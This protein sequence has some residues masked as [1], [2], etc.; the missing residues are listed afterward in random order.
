MG[1]TIVF[2]VSLGTADPA[3]KAVSYDL[4]KKDLEE[5]SGLP[6]WEI[7]TDRAAADATEAMTFEEALQKAEQEGYENIRIV[8][9]FLTKGD[10]FYE[11]KHTVESYQD[12]FDIKI[13]DA[14]LADRDSTAFAAGILTQCLH[15][16]PDREYVLAAY[17]NP[18]F[19]GMAYEILQTAFDRNGYD[20][21][22]VAQK[23]SNPG[24]PECVEFLR[25]RREGRTDLKPVIL[26]PLIV[27]GG[28]AQ[29]DKLIGETDSFASALR[30]AG[31]EVEAQNKGLG[32][33]KQFRRIYTIRLSS[34]NRD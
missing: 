23:V 25:R 24:V 14:V 4:I 2:E 21:V 29:M 15:M 9:I 5:A 33:Y 13:S 26:V 18:D 12:R 31:Y 7:F 10:L 30:E 28:N 34:I 8:P 27:S 17:G 32:E 11:T 3:I 1:K 6:V 20:N 19:S 16:D 22:F